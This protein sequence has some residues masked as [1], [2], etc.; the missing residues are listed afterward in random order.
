MKKNSRVYRIIVIGLMIIVA[1][2][3]AAYVLFVQDKGEKTADK[4]AM[5]ENK[6]ITSQVNE[7]EKDKT[8]TD[9]IQTESD[10]Q[11][12]LVNQMMNGDFSGMRETD[13]ISREDAQKVYENMGEETEFILA[14]M[15]HDGTKDLVWQEKE[16][17]K[18]G[19]PIIA[20][21]DMSNRGRCEMWD[22]ID[23]TEYFFVVGKD[24]LVYHAPYFGVYDYVPYWEYEYDETWN[25]TKIGGICAYYIYNLEEMEGYTFEDMPE[26]GVYFWECVGE[27]KSAL[28]RAEFNKKFK[29]LTY[30]DCEYLA[31][32]PDHSWLKDLGSWTGDY[33]YTENFSHA[34]D[35]ESQYSCGYKIR[36]Y[37]NN[38]LYYAMIEGEG[39]QLQTR[40][41]ARVRGSQES[42][43]LFFEETLQGDALYGTCERYDNLEKLL[44]FQ[45]GEELKTTWVALK[46]EHPIF[47]DKEEDVTGIYFEQEEKFWER[48]ETD[49]EQAAGRYA[50]N[51]TV[52]VSME[53]V[54]QSVYDEQDRLIATI[55]YDKPVVSGD[56]EVSAKINTFFENEAQCF[57]GNGESRHISGEM[58][59][60]FLEGIGIM[61]ERY[62]IDTL[63]EYPVSYVMNTRIS[64][65]DENVLG[66]MQ[67]RTCRGEQT[68]FH[69]VG[70][71]FNLATGEV[72]PITDFVEITPDEIRKIF[73]NVIDDEFDL[74]GELEGN[75]FLF[76]DGTITYDMRYQYI[77]D[78]EYCYLIEIYGGKNY[79][80]E[81]LI[82]LEENVDDVAVF[83]C[84][85]EWDGGDKIRW[86]KFR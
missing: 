21:F 39:E 40:S 86:Q 28:T 4:A 41:L 14:D 36:V 22:T 82:R 62:G 8:Q 61:E 49:E 79:L 74:Y 32:F 6:K 84:G 77:Y 45:K 18:I 5:E 56:A 38:N 85:T 57:L 71:T 52:E 23:G 17:T 27:E 37:E 16:E 78:G 80:C 35:E 53:R 1:A 68:D 83:T 13:R 34:T 29:E 69:H 42:I 3:I 48:I 72:M 66:I 50:N 44:S 30:V 24:K 46:Q 51:G 58:Y 47:C 65:L 19:K 2:I 55:Y 15:N 76:T 73:D 67:I 70:Y 11:E 7:K 25:R 10:A 43:N 64:Y 59:E 26:V 63:A 20:I 12:D 9:K 81:L 33:T 75:N 31:D 54:D 60:Q